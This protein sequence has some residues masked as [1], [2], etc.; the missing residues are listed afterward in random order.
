MDINAIFGAGTSASA[1]SGARGGADLGRDEFLRM[2]I[3]QLENQ[4]PLNPQDAT[5]FTAQLAQFS[6]LDQLFSMRAAIDNLAAAQGGSNA[7][8]VAS[9][10]GRRVLVAS[11]R[12]ERLAGAEAP[13][14][15]LESG[16]PTAILG[17]EL[18]DDAGRLVAQ[19]G[20]RSLP[21]GRSALE[22]ADFGGAPPPGTYSL[23]VT[24]AGGSAQPAVL[25]DAR[26]TG[27]SFDAGRAT[28]LLG[29]EPVS[30]DAL[31]AVRE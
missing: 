11:S 16:V 8:S 18:R 26:V 2:L 14:L 15:A 30:L 1:A 4:D 25:V 23:R 28:L 6:S 19:L 27:A 24:P 21:A 29:A 31:R 20:P 12:F 22:W 10:I 13:Q 9:L 5:E 17:A 3:T 7:L